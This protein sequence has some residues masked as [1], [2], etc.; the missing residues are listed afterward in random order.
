MLYYSA[1][2]LTCS[3][4]LCDQGFDLQHQLSENNFD[5]VA[6]VY[7]FKCSKKKLKNLAN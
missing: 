1:I 6:W 2:L 7:A 4:K 5:C 3:W